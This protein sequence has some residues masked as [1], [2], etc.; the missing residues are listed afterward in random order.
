M[1]P[2]GNPSQV[3]KSVL[4]VLTGLALMFASAAGYAYVRFVMP[5]ESTETTADTGVAACEAI[6]AKSQ[7]DALDDVVDDATIENLKN[8]ANAD[9][10]AAGEAF[11]R[12]AAMPDPV[13]EEE[14]TAVL[15]EVLTAMSKVS[16]GC[17]AVGVPL[18]TASL[19]TT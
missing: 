13:T 7:S 6:L 11:G 8:S 9:L 12:I 10:N 14:S 2:V 17:A 18:P 1:K 19:T 5:D 15:T 4:A 3:V 16:T